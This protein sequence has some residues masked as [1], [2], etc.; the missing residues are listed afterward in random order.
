VAVLASGR[1]EAGRHALVFDAAAQRLASG[2]YVV[3]VT[4]RAGDGA[5]AETAVRRMTLAR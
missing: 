4:A 5:T 2:V 1:F 3:H